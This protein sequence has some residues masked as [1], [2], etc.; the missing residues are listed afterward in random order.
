VP[1]GQTYLLRCQNFEEQICLCSLL[2]GREGLF[3]KDKDIHRSLWER[4]PDPRNYI[5][6]GRSLPH[7]KLASQI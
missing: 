1:K 4:S 6:R 7:F 2:T 3:G 5:G